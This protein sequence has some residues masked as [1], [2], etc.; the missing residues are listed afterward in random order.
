MKTI[1]ILAGDHQQ[2]LEHKDIFLAPEGE[3][4]VYCNR[5]EKILANQFDELRVVGTFWDRK[6]AGDIFRE[7]IMRQPDLLTQPN[8]Q[9]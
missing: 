1:A 9:K 3:R 4:M 8:N 7:F 5:L 2:Y 6:D